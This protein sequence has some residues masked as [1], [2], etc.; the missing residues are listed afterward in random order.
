MSLLKSQIRPKS[1]PG[2]LPN[3]GKSDNPR[4]LRCKP[5]GPLGNHLQKMGRNGFRGITGEGKSSKPGTTYSKSRH[6]PKLPNS[7]TYLYPYNLKLRWQDARKQN[8][9]QYTHNYNYAAYY[10]YVMTQSI[11]LKPSWEFSSKPLVSFICAHTLFTGTKINPAKM[12]I[13]Q[14]YGKKKAY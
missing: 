8:R 3:A 2:T 6:S 10:C 11:I 14:V 5:L 12:E 1:R 7:V 13:I 4:P 9:F